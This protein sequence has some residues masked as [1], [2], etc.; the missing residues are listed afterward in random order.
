MISSATSRAAP[1][2]E[3]AGRWTIIRPASR[4]VSLGLRELWDHGELVYFFAWRDVKVRYKQTALGALWAIL[5]PTLTVVIFS[6]FF[7][8]L[9]RIPSDGIP[10]PIFAFAGLVPWM[11]FA[12]G[13]THIA[14]SLVDNA[15]ML[16]K[17]YFPR[18]ALPIASLGVILVDFVLAFAVLL[19]MLLASGRT[20][21]AAILL[22]PAF[23]LLAVVSVLG[24][25]LW[26]A[27]VNVRFRDVRYTVPFLT[28]IWL[29]AT[30]VAYPSS[31]LSEPWRTVFGLNPMVGVVDGFRWA[32]LGTPAPAGS[33]A[34]SALVAVAAL[35]LG[36]RAFRRSERVFADI[37]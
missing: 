27:A 5:Q 35:F 13:L 26:L 4:R 11:L 34:V 28:Q 36:L 20:P 1:G 37:I 19:I 18:L 23:L 10:Y 6:V 2:A 8:R 12:N 24:I 22:L 15:P 7:G 30:P 16:K 25:G 33:T 14:N 3:S 17:V 32:L 31:L 9:G 21:S 29:F